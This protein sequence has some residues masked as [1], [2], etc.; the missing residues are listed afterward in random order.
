MPFYTIR[1]FTVLCAILSLNGISNISLATADTL[2]ITSNYIEMQEV[3]K[4]VEENSK[5]Q[6]EVTRVRRISESVPKLQESL[7]ICN[8]AQEDSAASITKLNT[9][10][11]SLTTENTFLNSFFEYILLTYGQPIELS[12]VGVVRAY[13]Y[14]DSLLIETTTEIAEALVKKLSKT[15]TRQFKYN[16]KVYLQVAKSSIIKRH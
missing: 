10:N 5:L 11:A 9:L 6:L 12:S 3:Q 14:G 15:P 4:L 7:A 1:D 16:G 2:E 8:S 13:E